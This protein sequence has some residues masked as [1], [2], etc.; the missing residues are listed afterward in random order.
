MKGITDTVH[1]I[2]IIDAGIKVGGAADTEGLNRGVF[3]KDA[4]GNSLVGKVWPGATHFVDF[5]HPNATQ[6]W[7]EMLD[8]LYSKVKFSGIWLDM[9][10]IANFCDGPCDQPKTKGFDYTNDLPYIPGAD[11]IETHTIP[12]NSTH[13]GNLKEADVHA[14]SAMLETYATNTYLK[15][16]NMK[17]FIITRGS[18]MGSN[19]FGF[20]WTGDN[21]V[22][23]EF[24]KGSIADNFN[25]Q[26]WGFQMVGADICGFAGNTTE[27]LCS[28]WFQLGSLYPFARDHTEINSVPQ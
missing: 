26:L 24:L 4:D 23:F 27:E 16:K 17:P 10:E 15:S 25:N 13:Y 28:R 12:L 22:S 20:H 11:G 2:P 14:F 5:F 9:N 3:I 18:T 1:Y 19:K 21:G 7:G 6:F 8:K